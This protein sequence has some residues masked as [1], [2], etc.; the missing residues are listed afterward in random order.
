MPVTVVVGAQWGDEGK[1]KVI[2]LLAKEHTYVVRYQGGHNAGHTVVVGGER[3]ALQLV[4]SGILYDHVVPVIGNGVVVDLPTLFAEVDTL[5]SRGVSCARLQVSS[6]AHL[7]FPWHQAHDA[8][9]EAMRGDDK[10]GTTL[11]GIGPAY[12]DKARRVGLRAGDVLDPG[13]F[14]AHV[15]ARAVAENREIEAAGGQALD[16]DEIVERFTALGGPADAVRR[17]HRGTAPRGAGRRSPP[18]VGG[19]PGDVP[20]PRPRHL[21]LCHVVEP[22]G[23]RRVRRDRPRPARHRSGRGDHQ[24]VH[25]PRRRRTLPDRAHRSRRRPARRRRPRVRHGH[26]TPPAGRVVGLRDAAPCRAPEQPHRVGRDEARCPR[27]VRDDQGVHGVPP[28]RSPTTR[29][30]GPLRR[31]RPSRAGLRDAAGVG[32]RAR[33]HARTG[34]TAGRCP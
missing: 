17:R 25:D 14:A 7:I 1:A 21:S 33:G 12:A 23:R 27:R 10:I 20:R 18:A 22:D 28:R 5:E 30:P 8:I 16:V 31:P 19:R 32:H 2:D 6:R 4:P 26:R 3:Y 11:K 13:S 34:P 9:A 29:L 15:K 24:G